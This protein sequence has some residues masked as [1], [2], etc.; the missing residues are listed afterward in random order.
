MSSNTSSIR[1]SNS[2]CMGQCALVPGSDR[3]EDNVCETDLCSEDVPIPLVYTDG[4]FCVRGAHV[5]NDRDV[6]ITY[7]KIIPYIHPNLTLAW[8]ISV[9]N[10]SLCKAI[11]YNIKVLIVSPSYFTGT[12]SLCV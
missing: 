1:L 6:T 3:R 5:V 11:C 10:G 9:S 2:S 7:C 12:F 8:N 4:M